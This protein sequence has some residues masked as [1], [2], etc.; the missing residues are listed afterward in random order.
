LRQRAE[1]E[2]KALGFSKGEFSREVRRQAVGLMAEL[3][4][5][6]V[7]EV[8]GISTPTL[9]KWRASLATE[10]LESESRVEYL[11]VTR[12]SLSS[13]SMPQSSPEAVPVARFWIGETPVDIF[14]ASVVLKTHHETQGRAAISNRIEC[15]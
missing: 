3:G 2:R 6:K 14:S 11:S 12:L 8:A 9:Y 10:Q 7:S 4:I 5:I 13:E 15:F 1:T